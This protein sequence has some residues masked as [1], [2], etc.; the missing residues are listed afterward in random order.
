MTAPV[1]CP[2]GSKC[3]QT[4]RQMP[5]KTQ[6]G[7]TITSIGGLGSPE[8]CQAKC[9]ES[10]Y[11]NT[12]YANGLVGTNGNNIG[13]QAIEW[14]RSNKMCWLLIFVPY[15]EDNSNSDL[16]V[17]VGAIAPSPCAAGEYSL[18][19]WSECKSCDRGQY[20][21]QGSKD[22]TD[23]GVGTFAASPGSASC[24]KCGAGEY[25]AS[26]KAAICTRCPAG[27]ASSAIGATSSLTCVPCKEGSYTAVAIGA[28]TCT[29]CPLGTWSAAGSKSLGA[30]TAALCGAGYYCSG[31]VKTA[32]APGAWAAAGASV[33]TECTKT[34][35]GDGFHCSGGVRTPCPAGTWAVSGASASS[36]CSAAACGDGFYCNG[37]GV[38]TPCPAGTWAVSGASASS[39]CSA[40][41]CGDGYWCLGGKREA[42]GVGLWVT[43]GSGIELNSCTNCE[44]GH[45]CNGAGMKTRCSVNTFSAGKDPVCSPCSTGSSSPAGSSHCT[46]N[47]DYYGKDGKAPCIPCAKGSSSVASSSDCVCDADYWRYV[48]SLGVATRFPP[49]YCLM[50]TSFC[51]T[52][53]N[54]IT[55][56]P[57]VVLPQNRAKHV[58]MAVHLQRSRRCALAVLALK[59]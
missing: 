50:L 58:L 41:L 12:D 57:D 24:T 4:F 28:A 20:S 32:C 8:A 10:D 25:A 9:V 23:C 31:G 19:G 52:L 16:Y 15:P 27:S 26:T 39:L 38:R 40:A 42:C 5:G 34:L 29:G 55:A 45:I 37:A 7:A 11:Q 13:C 54:E 53:N 46:C 59:V 43:A 3:S 6:F 18:A 47:A 44:P 51:F 56:L 36:S 21:L 17:K 22:C 49:L 2:A 1:L 33:S 14:E 30:C 48:F 35:C